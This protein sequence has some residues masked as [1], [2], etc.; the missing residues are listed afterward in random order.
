[1]TWEETLV[2]RFRLVINDFTS[3]QVW[4]DLQLQKFIALGLG[5]LD[6]TL[7]DWPTGGPYAITTSVSGVTITPDP[8]LNDA[9]VGFQN[10]IL[11]KAGVLLSNAEIKKTLASA[12]FKIVDDKSTIDSSSSIEAAKL[13]NR[14]FEDEYQ[15]TLEDFMSGNAYAGSA[16][17]TPYSSNDAYNIVTLRPWEI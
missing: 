9:S 6:D 11:L 3:P 8:T 10:L 13:K 5:T 2:D 12:G 15:K 17:L 4:T 14:I 1:M 16:I 7:K